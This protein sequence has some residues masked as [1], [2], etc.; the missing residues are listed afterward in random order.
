MAQPE[1]K[2]SG[3]YILHWLWQNDK[4]PTQ[5]GVFGLDALVKWGD[6]H[7]CVHSSAP[8]ICTS[9]SHS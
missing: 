1:A 9:F 2:P 3:V 6:N 4:N 8:L 7:V 5:A